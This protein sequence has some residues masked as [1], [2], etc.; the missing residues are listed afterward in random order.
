MGD[1][2]V[3]DPLRE[4]RPPTRD[5]VITLERLLQSSSLRVRETHEDAVATRV[6]NRTSSAVAIFD[7]GLSAEFQ[8]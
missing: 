1:D 6:R 8:F 2:Q 3:A 5:G 4:R 7:L